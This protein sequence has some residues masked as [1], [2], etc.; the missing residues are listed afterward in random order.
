MGYLIF[1][2]T[3]IRRPA[4]L[5][6]QKKKSSL[7]GFRIQYSRFK[8]QKKLPWIQPPWIQDSRFK[9]E[10]PL[11]SRFF[12]WIFKSWIQPSW[13]QDVFSGSW[14][15]NRTPLDSKFFLDLESWI[16]CSI[17]RVGLQ[18]IEKNMF[19]NPKKC[20]KFEV[21]NMWTKT[22]K[23]LHNLLNWLVLGGY[24]CIYIYVYIV[25]MYGM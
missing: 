11:D 20:P 15:L 12:S 4:R 22:L 6:T 25:C 10:V 16:R 14:I 3:H 8:A 7:V 2:Q 19:L 13:I 24:L 23:I 5:K 21:R 18:Q 1:R 17:W 9:A